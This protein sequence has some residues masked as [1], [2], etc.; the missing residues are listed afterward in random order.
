MLEGYRPRGIAGGLADHVAR[1][2]AGREAGPFLVE[3]G[4]MEAD[5]G[6]RAQRRQ[7]RVRLQGRPPTGTVLQLAPGSWLSGFSGPGDV[8]LGS[9]LL[10]VGSFEDEDVENANSSAALWGLDPPSLGPRFAHRGGAGVRMQRSEVDVSERLLTPAHRMLVAPRAR[11]S[12]VGT[13]RVGANA[14][15]RVSLN[16][17]ADTRGPSRLRRRVRL[18]R[19]G[20]PGWRAFRLDVTVPAGITAASPYFRLPRPA[21][22]SATVDV[23]DVALIQWA[24]P[25]ARP[26]PLYDWLLVRGRGVGT[27]RRD[28]LPGG[29]A[30]SPLGS[31][32]TLR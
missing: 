21:R 30:W 6:H 29:G 28:V 5:L 27:L 10:W 26:S 12:L 9:D 2:A 15:P 16:L 19:R 22:G 18:G 7:R 23:D 24:G 17:Y 25:R 31:I 32:R 20:A 11:L 14:R 3:N 13:M 8:R 4:A 1:E